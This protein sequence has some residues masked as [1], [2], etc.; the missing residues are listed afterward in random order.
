MEPQ[1][2]SRYSQTI[3][4]QLFNIIEKASPEMNEIS[5]IH[6]LS[7]HEVLTFNKTTTDLRIVYDASAHCKG[8]KSL[9][10]VLYRGPITL[11]DLNV[12]LLCFRTVKNIIIAGV[13]KA[14]L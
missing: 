13:E 8:M 9:N 3:E 6:Y 2:L 14:F 12:V 11:P 10:D 7:H 1:L 4:E 5:I